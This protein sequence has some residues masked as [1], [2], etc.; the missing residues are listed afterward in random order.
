[1][2]SLIQSFV[3]AACAI[4]VLS[5]AACGNSGQNTDNG[6]GQ[7]SDNGTTVAPVADSIQTADS[8]GYIVTTGETVPQFDLQLPDGTK[9]PI[10]QLKGKV[11]MLQ[12]TAS[13]SMPQGNA[14]YR[15][16]YLAEIKR[17]S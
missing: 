17:Q 7:D 13:W 11:V 2:K 4:T 9:I 3:Y 14:F 12:F 15:K 5:L 1:M 16:R 6:A 10:D 8:R